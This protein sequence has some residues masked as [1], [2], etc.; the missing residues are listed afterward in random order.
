M[1]MSKSP[2]TCLPALFS[3]RVLKTVGSKDAVAKATRTYS[4][5]VL[6]ADQETTCNE[7]IAI[8]LYYGNV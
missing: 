5:R 1:A 4:R 7:F 2:V 3:D 8:Y 6:M